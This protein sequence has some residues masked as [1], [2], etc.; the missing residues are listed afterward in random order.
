MTAF[1]SE[2]CV[3]VV[4]VCVRGGGGGGVGGK[5]E[6]RERTGEIIPNRTLVVSYYV[7]PFASPFLHFQLQLS[8]LL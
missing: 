7:P 4:C 6:G 3:C 1:S 5:E 2:L 8:I